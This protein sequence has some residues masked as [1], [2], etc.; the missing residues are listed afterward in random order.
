MQSLALMVSER[1]GDSHGVFK[2]RLAKFQQQRFR[3]RLT[4]KPQN[5]VELHHGKRQN[6]GQTVALG[7]E[8]LDFV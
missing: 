8:S 2:N 1:W 6:I 3:A 7:I 4:N 5:H